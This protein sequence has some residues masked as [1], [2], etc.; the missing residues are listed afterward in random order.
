MRFVF[1]FIFSCIVASCGTQKNAL[2]ESA[3]YSF[4]YESFTRGHRQIIEINSEKTHIES[5]AKQIDT[6]LITPKEN[7]KTLVTEA[8]KIDLSTLA[9][10][11]A[12]SKKH[13]FDGAAAASLLVTKANTTYQ[14]A[15]FDHGNPPKEIADLINTITALEE[16]VE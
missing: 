7:W 10:L 15:S 2:M 6:V 3:D 12:P 5:T 8:N 1:L 16:A 14:S 9:T 4:R 13:M 11:K